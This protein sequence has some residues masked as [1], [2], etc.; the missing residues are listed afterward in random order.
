[1]NGR[2]ARKTNIRHCIREPFSY[3]CASTSTHKQTTRTLAAPRTNWPHG[4]F[5]LS[6][7]A[8]GFSELDRRDH[9][10]I[11]RFVL[12]NIL[13]CSRRHDNIYSEDT[14]A[15]AGLAV[16]EVVL[17]RVRQ[18]NAGKSPQVTGVNLRSI[19]DERLRCHFRWPLAA[20]R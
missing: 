9:L 11:H 13:R 7:C 1:M 18:R 12:D 14:R 4:F 20:V 6:Q 2:L 8:L 19:S 10:R 17:F 5:H 3:S 15:K 16:R